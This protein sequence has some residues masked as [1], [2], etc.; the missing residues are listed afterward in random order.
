[1]SVAVVLGSAFHDGGLPGI[2][3]VPEEVGGVVGAREEA[4]G[5]GRSKRRLDGSSLPTIP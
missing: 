1:M 3:L 5:D 2:E 4:A